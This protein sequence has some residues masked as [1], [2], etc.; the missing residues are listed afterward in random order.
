VMEE[1]P[2]AQKRLQVI[3]DHLAGLINA[4]EA[5]AELGI[6]RKT[7]YEWLERAQEAMFRA[8]TDKPTGRPPEP[9]DPEKVELQ[10]KVSTLEKER[11]VLESRL[12]IREAIWQTLNEGP[13]SKKKPVE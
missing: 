6:S 5:S 2:K 10:E 7:F 1:D 12:R 3:L 11:T 9:V 4:T 8:L 13:P